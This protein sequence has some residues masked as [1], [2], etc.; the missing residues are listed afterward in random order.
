MQRRLTLLKMQAGAV[1]ANYSSRFAAISTAS[2]MTSCVCLSMAA[3]L[4]RPTT[5]SLAI[6]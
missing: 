2:T 3:F 6:T 4:R 5:S 1:R